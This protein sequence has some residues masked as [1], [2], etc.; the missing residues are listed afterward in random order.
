[1]ASDDT[2]SPQFYSFGDI[3]VDDIQVRAGNCET[4]EPTG[5]V[6]PSLPLSSTEEIAVLRRFTLDEHN[7]R[8]EPVKA[9]LPL[10]QNLQAHTHTPLNSARQLSSSF[11]GFQDFSCNFDFDTCS[12]YLESADPNFT[13][14]EYTWTRYTG[15]TPTAGTGPVQDRTTGSGEV[16][17][18]CRE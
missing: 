15:S 3:A 8:T 5:T 12:Q 7:P 14:A 17:V 18:T 10:L 11:V 2:I 6:S 1:M 4:V 16:T 9:A 13:P